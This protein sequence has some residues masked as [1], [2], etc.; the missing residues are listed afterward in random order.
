M[1]RNFEAVKDKIK[2]YAGI[3]LMLFMAAF[4]ISTLRNIYKVYKA[5]GQVDE[6]KARI[7]KLQDENQE[8][9]QEIEKVNSDAYKESQLRNK[10]G[11]AKE[12][13]VVVVLPEPDVLR[14]L[15]PKVTKEEIF[16][17][18]PN[19]KQWLKLFL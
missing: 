15:A 16:L 13:E 12:G 19:W 9:Q 17:P 10:L 4:L 11:L 5:K 14:E 6:I 2:K 7:A 8:L 3:L 18:D 1:D